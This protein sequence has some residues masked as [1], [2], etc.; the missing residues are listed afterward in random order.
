[1]ALAFL[2]ANII[3]RYVTQDDPVLAKKAR[4]M[5]KCVKEGS[6][7]VT[8]CESIL[9]ECVY[10]L[11]SKRLYHLPRTHIAAILKVILSFR[12]LKMPHKMTYQRA[13]N[14][15]ASSTIDFPDTLAVAHMERMKIKDIYSFDKDFD[16]FA[17]IRGRTA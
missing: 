5:L 9:T 1:M 2:D 12:G 6:L 17:G 8:T 13:L 11:S 10:I 7:L 14:L 16:K 15:Y 3:I 4:A